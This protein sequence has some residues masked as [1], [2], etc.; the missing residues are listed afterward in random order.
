MN[1]RVTLSHPNLNASLTKKTLTNFI[2]DFYL[3]IFVN[4]LLYIYDSLTQK[5][6][7]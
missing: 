3:L 6:V 1:N 4:K 2:F 5:Q 7:K